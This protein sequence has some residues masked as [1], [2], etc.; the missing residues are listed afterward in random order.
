M[1]NNQANSRSTPDKGMPGSDTAVEKAD[2]SSH[3]KRNLVP[4]NEYAAR[5]GISSDIVEQQGQLGV[6]QIRKFKGQTFVVD[7]PPEQ[8]SEFETE[9]AAVITRKHVRPQTT[10]SSR[11]FTIG[12]TDGIIIII[13]DVSWLYMDAKTKLDDLNAEYTSIQ[14]RYNELASEKQSLKAM[15]EQLAA[16]KAEFA[17]IQNQIASSKTD[18]EKIQSDLNKTKRNLEAIQSGLTTMQG[19]TSLSKVELESIQNNLTESKNQLDALSK[20]NGTPGTK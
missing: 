12:L 9:D 13:T 16:A 15:Q 10:T 5:R 3:F 4:L 1:D 7:V 19:Q 8:L 17:R 18:L 2:S 20:Q 6:V 14:K 11:I